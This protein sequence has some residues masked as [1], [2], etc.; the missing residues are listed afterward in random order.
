MVINEVGRELDVEM[1]HSTG[2]TCNRKLRS[3]VPLLISGRVPNTLIGHDD[4]GTY[5]FLSFQCA[6]VMGPLP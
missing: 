3:R 2:S 4:D 6:V 1:V 5:I